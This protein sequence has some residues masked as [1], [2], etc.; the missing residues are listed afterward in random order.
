MMN[1]LSGHSFDFCEP[2]EDSKDKDPVQNLGQVVFGERLR[3]S[4]YDVS[5]T[6]DVDSS[7]V[8]TYGHEI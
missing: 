2:G 3:A 6:Q 8:R 7:L 5:L 4:G 1:A